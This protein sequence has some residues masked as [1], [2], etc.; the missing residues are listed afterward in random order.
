LKGVYFAAMTMTTV[1][2]G[3]IMPKNP[4][5]YG[6]CICIMVFS[7]GFFAYSLNTITSILIDNEN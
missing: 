4:I 1:G 3:D 2:Y 7:C 5:E 6:A